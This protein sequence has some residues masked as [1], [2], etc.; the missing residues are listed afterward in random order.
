MGRAITLM[1]LGMFDEA[2]T[3]FDRKIKGGRKNLP[4]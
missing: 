2:R 3:A 4:P 1:E